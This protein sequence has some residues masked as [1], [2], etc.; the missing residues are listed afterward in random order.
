MDAQ[1]PGRFYLNIVQGILI[2]VSETWVVT[3]RIGMT[4]EGLHYQVEHQIIDK[5]QWQKVDASW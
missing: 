3:P 1:R 4:L 2:F 5:Q